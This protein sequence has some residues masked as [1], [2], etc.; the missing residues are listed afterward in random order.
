MLEARK[1]GL[2]HSRYH[3]IT[4]GRPVTTWEGS[5]W[6]AGGKFEVDGRQYQVS[7]N[8]FATTYQMVDAVGAV[9]ASANR[10]G[11]KNWT[12]EANGVTYQFRRP[13]WW[14]QE[15]ELLSHGQPVGTVRRTS[16]WR[17][18]AAADLPG[19]PL[20]TQVFVLCVVLTRWDQSA[21]AATTAAV[22]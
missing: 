8:T 21:A 1:A 15:E 13:S 10:V 7:S 2:W 20:P 19:L 5:M 16:M 4:D 18:D 17:G 3:I 22:T 9:V 11:R 6:K 12:V 14:R